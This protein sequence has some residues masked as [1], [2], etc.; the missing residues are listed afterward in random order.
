MSSWIT[1]PQRTIRLPS[2]MSKTTTRATMGNKSSIVFLMSWS[3]VERG[4]KNSIQKQGEIHHGQPLLSPCRLLVSLSFRC[5]SE[6][7]GVCHRR[8]QQGTYHRE[9]ERT[10]AAKCLQSA[11]NR[12]PHEVREN[13]TWPSKIEIEVEVPEHQQ[14]FEDFKRLVDQFQE[15]LITEQEMLMN[16]ACE[17]ANALDKLPKEE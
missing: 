17:S 4:R 1:L 16:I 15:G 3:G 9:C 6:G 7:K 5:V 10:N 11:S 14:L 2:S 12:P 13:Q 8:C